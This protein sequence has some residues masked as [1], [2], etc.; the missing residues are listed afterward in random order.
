MGERDGLR[1]IKGQLSKR[2][3]P[4]HMESDQTNGFCGL[5]MF[6]RLKVDLTITSLFV[7]GVELESPIF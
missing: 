6:D 3:M 2:A 4:K 1:L 5:G 7:Q